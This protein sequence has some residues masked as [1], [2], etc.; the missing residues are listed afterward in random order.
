MKQDPEIPMPVMEQHTIEALGMN[1]SYP[2]LWDLT[3]VS[4]ES[5]LSFMLNS[6]YEDN[7]I[8][9]MS[10]LYIDCLLYTSPSPRD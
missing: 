4:A 7:N 5:T 9:D 6:R 1:I 8:W 10:V 3:E 2:Y